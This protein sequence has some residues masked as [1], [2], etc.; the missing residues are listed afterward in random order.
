MNLIDFKCS[1]EGKYKIQI[2]QGG[3]IVSERPW[4]KNMILNQG[5]DWVMAGTRTFAAS[6]SHCAVGTG[7]TP[8]AAT[9]TG[10]ASEAATLRTNTY[11]TGAGNCGTS[12]V[13]QVGTLRRTYEFPL[14]TANQNYTELG[15]SWTATKASNLF[16]RTLIAGG[17]VTVLAEQQ[18]RVV[19]DVSI[20]CAPTGVQTGTLTVAGWGVLPGTWALQS[21]M[22]AEI[23][24]S[25]GASLSGGLF[26]PKDTGNAAVRTGAAVLGSFGS[27]PSGGALAASVSGTAGTYTLGTFTR[28]VTFPYFTALSFA[29]TDVRMFQY[30]TSGG[31][32]AIAFR[33]DS[34][35]TKL[36][37]YRLRPNGYR[38]TIS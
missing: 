2:L 7:T 23:S 18:L 27:S 26:E 31:S 6:F 11:L 8:V 29:S 37:T 33:F 3:V 36:N 10:L 9:D 16:S 24:T 21:G 17:T 35:Q 38:I 13:G 30:S 15:W 4:A 22:F 14:E 1:I 28:S 25:G 20:T 12:W 32:I 5:K 34:P 19:Y